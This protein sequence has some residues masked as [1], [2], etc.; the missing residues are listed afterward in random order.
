MKSYHNRISGTEILG[1]SPS[2][3]KDPDNEVAT[4]Q[5]TAVVDITFVPHNNRKYPNSL[6][7]HKIH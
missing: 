5:L 7:G 1:F 6:N 2:F 4:E 3:G